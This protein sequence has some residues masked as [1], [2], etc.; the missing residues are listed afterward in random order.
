MNNRIIVIDDEESILNDYQMIL[1]PPQEDSSK[2][3]EMQDLEAELF[4]ASEVHKKTLQ[5]HY[6]VSAALQGKEGAE[7]VAEAKKNG[8]PFA[9]AFIDIRMPP[10]WDGVHTA[11]KIREIDSDIEIVMV[12]A[13]SDRD[14]REIVSEVSRPEKLLYIKK[15][16]DPDEI[17]Q[18]ALCLTRKWEL[19]QKALRHRNYLERLLDSVRR[20]KTLNI[21]SVREVLAAILNE[22]LC[23]VHARKGFIARLE[24]GKVCMEIN[25]ENLSVA[26]IGLL[27]KNVS[28]QL[29][30]I[31]TISWIDNIMI[32]P[33]QN[34]F[35]NFFILV[36]DLQPPVHEEKFELLR[37]LLGTS[38]EVLD[39]VSRHERF[40][41]NERIATI[42]QMAAGII[43]EI[44]N[45][46]TAMLGAADF[47]KT[48]GDKL[49]K[50]VGAYSD[51]L[52]HPDTP[53]EVMKKAEE[54]CRGLDPEKIRRKMKVHH[55]I[56]RDGV[57]RVRVLMKNI[58][59]F[60]SGSDQSEPKLQD[61][62]EAL[63]NT[64]MLAYNTIK[65]GISVCKEWESPL[66]ARCDIDS[67]RQVFLNLILNAAQAMDGR[68]E[69]RITAGRKNNKVIVSVSDS[70]PGIP[71]S[72]MKRIFEAFYTTKADGTGLG[73]SIV[74][75]IVDRHNGAIRVESEP[76]KGTTFHVELPGE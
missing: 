71:E 12:T 69:L 75:G 27:I 49:W 65:Y 47:Y 58:R 41:K 40:L 3:K 42:G 37:L 9:V 57:D 52:R 73:L 31:H 38:S 67:I 17:R 43:H 4:G 20:L 61:I 46:L 16:F 8:K 56:I 39:S 28:E 7:S 70:G 54:L 68:G 2:Q 72:E 5:E 66:L 23:F 55:F 60:S 45:P 18:L 50:L 44:N 1:S 32:F 34:G 51:I 21:S 13:Y 24:N 6:E 62:S 53:P 63:E 22:V 14:R 29:S 26:E 74:K 15:P 35:G 33:L 36:S 76:G 19:E 11:R 64:L 30:D 10:G 25:S 48:D 59:T